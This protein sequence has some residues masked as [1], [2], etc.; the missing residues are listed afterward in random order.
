MR[1]ALNHSEDLNEIMSLFSISKSALKGAEDRLRRK[2]RKCGCRR[3]ALRFVDGRH[4]EERLHLF[5]LAEEKVLGS[6][7]RKSWGDRYGKSM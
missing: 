6:V 7:D 4:G 2:N 3:A 5:Y 1:E